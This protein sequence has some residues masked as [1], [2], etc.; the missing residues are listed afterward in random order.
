MSL[1]SNMIIKELGVKETLIAFIEEI[2]ILD[3]EE[4]AEQLGQ[5]KNDRVLDKVIDKK[6]LK[7]LYWLK[8]SEE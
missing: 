2:S 5:N 3:A 1:K 8:G 7:K 6:N 4:M